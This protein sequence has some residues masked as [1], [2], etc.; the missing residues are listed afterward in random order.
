MVAG[1]QMTRSDEISARQ[2]MARRFNVEAS[3]PTRTQVLNLI[4]SPAV[5]DVL[6]NSP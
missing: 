3:T 4:Q 2:A 1:E 6:D 5:L